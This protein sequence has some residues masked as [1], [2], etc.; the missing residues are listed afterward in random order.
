VA[1]SGVRRGRKRGAL[2][3]A[4]A[5]ARS[6][7]AKREL[8]MLEEAF[9]VYADT[10]FQEWMKTAE[11][12]TATRERIHAAFRAVGGARQVLVQIIN[13]GAVAEGN[14]ALS[15]LLGRGK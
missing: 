14:A 12:D 1:D 6:Y 13:D 5:V 11:S 7:A 15:S 4:E 2:P 9:E 8:P 10:L 3:P